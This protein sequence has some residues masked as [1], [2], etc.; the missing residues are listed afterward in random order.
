MNQMKLKAGRS[1]R[2]LM[3]AA[4]PLAISHVHAAEY[5]LQAGTTSVT[6]PGAPSIAMWG[7]AQCTANFASCGTVTIPGPALGVPAGDATG[8]I[9][10]LKNTLAVPTSLVIPGQLTTMT[11]VWFEPI[12]GAIYGGAR[13]AGNLTARVRSFTHEAAPGGTAN[14]SWPAIKAGTYLYESGTH[15]QVQVQMGLYGALTSNAVEATASTLAQAYAGAAYDSQITLLYSEIDPAMHAAVANGTYGTAPSSTFNYQPKY[16]L[17][18]GRPYTAG[19]SPLATI[20]AGKKTLLRMLNAGL[21]THV[22]MLNGSY[23]Q[24]IAEDGNAYPY[25]TRQQYSVL[26]PAAKTI[27]GIVTPSNG[28]P[29]NLNLAI[30]DRRLDVTNAGAPDGGMLAFLAVAPG[31][32][33]PII[34]SSAKLTGAVGSL[35]TYQVMATDPNPGDTLSYSLDATSLANGMTINAATGL[36]SWTPSIAGSYSVTVQVTDQTGLF[37]TQAYVLVISS[38]NQPPVIASTPVTTASRNVAYTYAVIATDPNTGDVLTYSLDAFPA[39]MTISPVGVITWLPQVLGNYAVTI[40][41]TDQIGAFT[42]QSY[43]LAVVNDAPVAK[44]DGT[45]NMV[46]GSTLTVAVPGVLA[47]DT[48]KNADALTAV[49]YTVPATG[50]LTGQSNGS[51]TYLAPAGGSGA[52]T[53]T[54]QANDGIA[55]SAAATVTINVQANKPPGTIADSF[56]VVRRTSSN[57]ASFPVVLSVLGNDSD[58]DTVLDPNNKINTATVVISTGVNKGGSV[59][60][61]ANGTISYTPKLNFTGSETFAY[62]V[63]DTFN[64]LSSAATVTVN[65]K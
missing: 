28:G 1:A 34:T 29:G 36:I 4:L 11:P 65:V 22:P 43:S 24:M 25:M 48:D 41:V 63:R 44:N 55:T 47:N 9:V 8:L 61:N 40:K 37:A 39:G 19:A 52:K 50:T 21:K 51:F 2:L 12:G 62:K 6:M 17:I 33:A 5:W 60:V 3:L 30:L 38:A 49:N 42:T 32:A 26:L 45:Y 18:N 31:P 58:P 27:D 59:T 46:E 57:S 35:Y 23:M 56:N 20:T 14:Y 53:F 10:H 64:A 13:P 7:Y 54:Y 15:P 16:F